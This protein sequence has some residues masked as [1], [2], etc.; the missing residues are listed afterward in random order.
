LKNQ[1][2]NMKRNE[3]SSRYSKLPAEFWAFAKASGIGSA[4]HGYVRRLAVS[5]L[6]GIPPE[7]LR[8]W[9]RRD[10]DA[11][12]TASNIAKVKALLWVLGYRPDP[13]THLESFE[14]IVGLGITGKDDVNEVLGYGSSSQT[15]FPK[16]MAGTPMHAS[17]VRRMADHVSQKS[18]DVATQK[19]RWLAELRAVGFEP[20]AKPGD[21]E[22]AKGKPTAVPP[23]VHAP[24][25]P[26]AE[27]EVASKSVPDVR[28]AEATPA[29]ALVDI[30]AL[31]I[32]VL[33]PLVE[34]IG[35]VG[36]SQDRE[37]LRSLLADGPGNK[38]F[39]L[40]VA[41]APLCSETAARKQKK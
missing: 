23:S 14:I 21:A 27:P 22:A 15:M 9:A 5:K 19:V 18:G 28:I 24:P 33:L 8:T 16:V 7:N 34:H 39:R 38:V 25:D 32:K 20:K 31:H 13:V 3:E 4:G 1:D 17:K 35:T 11:H 6:F 10:G 40:Q 29:S 36:T 41:L 30:T 12:A 37:R 2:N 26:G